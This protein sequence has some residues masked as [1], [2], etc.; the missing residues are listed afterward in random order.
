MKNKIAL[1]TV[2]FGL[3]YGISNKAGKTSKAEVSKILEFCKEQGI[4]TLDTAYGYGVS[5][6]VLGQNDLSTFNLVTKFL[7]QDNGIPSIEKQVESSIELLN[8]DKLYGLLAHRPLD[9]VENPSN[10][11]YLQSLKERG[12]VLKI[13]FSFNTLNELFN[14]IENNFIPDLVQIPYNFL[15]RRFEDAI[16]ELKIKHDIEVHTRSTFLQGLFFMNMKELPVFFD[17]IKG[18]VEKIQT[19]NNA[20]IEN[21]LI[22]FVT[23]KLFIDKVVLGVNN[24]VQLEQNLNQL[25]VK[26]KTILNIELPE[27]PN[28][29]LT[30]SNWPKLS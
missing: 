24:L 14:V 4:L 8:V 20:P 30:P 7:P 11:K 6:E 17:P 12:K 21:T 29:I 5:Q 16:I 22:R 23:S 3:D 27:I 2:Q 28:Q 25:N 15:D 19:S 1:G 26:D 10:W 18:V 9:I 13:G